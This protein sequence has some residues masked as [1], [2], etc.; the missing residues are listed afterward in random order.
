MRAGDGRDTG[1]IKAEAAQRADSL[2]HCRAGR[3]DVVHHDDVGP[4]TKALFNAV[5]PSVEDPVI[6]RHCAAYC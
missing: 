3:H 6:D 5:C 1:N 2:V 4:L